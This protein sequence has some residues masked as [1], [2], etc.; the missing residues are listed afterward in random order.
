[1]VKITKVSIKNAFFQKNRKKLLTI[2]ENSDIILA[3]AKC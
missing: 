2:N 3:V 1:M